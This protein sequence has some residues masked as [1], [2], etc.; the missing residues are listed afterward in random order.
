MTTAHDHESY[1]VQN[2]DNFVRTKSK[3]VVNFNKTLNNNWKQSNNFNNSFVCLCF[4]L[5]SVLI[6]KPYVWA[7]NGRNVPIIWNSV[8]YDHTV[9]IYVKRVIT[10]A[11]SRITFD[12]CILTSSEN[13]VTLRWSVLCLMLNGHHTYMNDA[14]FILERQQ[15]QKEQQ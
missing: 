6:S 9:K 13:V 10:T 8:G 11:E 7:L 5:Y 3:S 12:K 4:D 1:T 15:Q 2:F 14:L